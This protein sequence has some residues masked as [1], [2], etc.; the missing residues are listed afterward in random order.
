[1]NKYSPEV[2][3]KKRLISDLQGKIKKGLV[4]VYTVTDPN[5][6]RLMIGQ[7]TGIYYGDYTNVIQ[8]FNV[9]K[10]I[11]FENGKPTRF[12]E[13][14]NVHLITD[15]DGNFIRII[16][17]VNENYCIMVYEDH[18]DLIKNTETELI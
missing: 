14:E 13:Y 4:D 9:A 18:W 7:R 6:K 17:E 5:E 3:M 10:D 11:K 8:S 2:L 1:M 12:D 15:R 16:I